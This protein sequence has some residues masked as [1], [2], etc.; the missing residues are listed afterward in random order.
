MND[1]DTNAPVV[2]K[3]FPAKY[4]IYAKKPFPVRATQFFQDVV[5]DISGK[6]T[7]GIKGDYLVLDEMG[8]LK[9]CKKDTFEK[10]YEEVS[11]GRW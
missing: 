7:P 3:R 8:K 6:Q 1:A 2:I 5:I 9:I 10:A 4:K 11:I